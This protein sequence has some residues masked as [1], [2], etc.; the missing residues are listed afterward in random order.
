M[1]SGKRALLGECVKF[2]VH[3]INMSWCKPLKEI[4]LMS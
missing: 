1:V 3:T 2:E 4:L